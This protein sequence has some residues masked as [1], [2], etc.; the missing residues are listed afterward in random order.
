MWER[1]IPGKL[2]IGLTSCVKI[3]VILK[4]VEALKL[5]VHGET[6][7]SETM[8]CFKISQFHR[9]RTHETFHETAFHATK[10][11]VS[12]NGSVPYLISCFIRLIG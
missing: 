3:S 6:F 5:A 11:S 1:V 8:K 2:G 7:V 9:V 12:S 4:F 10:I